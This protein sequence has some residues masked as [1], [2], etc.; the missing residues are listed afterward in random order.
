[1]F[2]CN[3][4]TQGFYHMQFRSQGRACP[5]DIAGILGDFRL[6]QDHVEFYHDGFQDTL[7]QI[8]WL[9]KTGN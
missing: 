9:R 7:Y 3:R 5:R 1:M 8:T 6:V 2:I 4:K